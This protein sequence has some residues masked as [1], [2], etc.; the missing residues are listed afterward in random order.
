MILGVTGHRPQGLGCGYNVPN[1]TYN[2]IC[3]AIKEEL[4]KI[5]PS[6]IIS[7][8]AQGVDSWAVHVALELG[9][10]YIAAVPCEGQDKAWP[11]YSKAHYK[12]LLKSAVEV[13]I[14]SPG[15][16]SPIKMK[17]RDEWLVDNCTSLLAVWSG[18]THGG[19]YHTVQYAK[20]KKDCMIHIIDPESLK[21]VV[22]EK[23]KEKGEE[24]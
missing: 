12:E 17:I 1:P 14:V 5:N 22:Y 20:S 18:I 21:E 2:K 10:P 11:D 23:E 9:I 3:K 19:T 6:K 24:S 13:V 8:M 7:G 4:I 15:G 16:Y